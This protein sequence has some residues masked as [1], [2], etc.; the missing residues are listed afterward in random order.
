MTECVLMREKFITLGSGEGDTYMLK[1]HD[2]SLGFIKVWKAGLE[3]G[4]VPM[5]VT[6]LR[7]CGKSWAACANNC[8][9][10]C[11]QLGGY[12]AKSFKLHPLLS[13][14]L[15]RRARLLLNNPVYARPSDMPTENTR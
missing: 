3:S 12:Q 6:K 7:S 4:G 2:S 1:A 13:K 15:L 14:H 11:M 8:L 10:T 9:E 5:A